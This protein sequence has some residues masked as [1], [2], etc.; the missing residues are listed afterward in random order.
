MRLH[1]FSELPYYIRVG[2]KTTDRS[3]IINCHTQQCHSPSSVSVGVQALPRSDDEGI[4]DAM[5]LICRATLVHRRHVS[6]P[7]VMSYHTNQSTA[8][9]RGI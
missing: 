6:E 9:L 4:G 8:T 5:R 3:D 1:P 2:R 7:G